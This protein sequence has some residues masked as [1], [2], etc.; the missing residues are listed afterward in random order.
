VGEGVA[1]A[2]VPNKIQPRKFSREK[3]SGKNAKTPQTQTRRRPGSP[4]S[5]KLDPLP[6]ELQC[7][8][9]LDSPQSTPLSHFEKAQHSRHEEYSSAGRSVG[10]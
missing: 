4:H 8:S 2:D 1:H 6:P 9:V 5:K 3:T 7:N 10:P